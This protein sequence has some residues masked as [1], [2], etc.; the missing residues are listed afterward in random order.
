VKSYVIQWK[1]DGE[2]FAGPLHVFTLTRRSDGWH[3]Y[4][5]LEFATAFRAVAAPMSWLYPTEEAA[6]SEAER[7]WSALLASW[8]TP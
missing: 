7:A 2:G 4:A 5:G 8:V 3:L 1:R 6:K